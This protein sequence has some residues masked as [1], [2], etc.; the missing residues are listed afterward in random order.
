M[1]ISKSISSQIKESF[2]GG[3]WTGSNFKEH[4]DG[5]SWE[6][7]LIKIDSINTI[8]ALT[9]HVNFFVEAILL[10]LNKEDLSLS[11]KDSYNHPPINNSDDW[12]EMK[13]K[14]W[15][16]VD[17]FSELIALLP[18]AKLEE[19]FWENKYGNYYRNIHGVIEHSHYHLGQIVLIKNKIRSSE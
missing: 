19:D 15:K 10:V 13:T 3:N 18:D 5:I 1:S 16:N 12:E 4:L 8:V 9:Y 7:A 6:E 17:E 14:L 11:D 2:Y